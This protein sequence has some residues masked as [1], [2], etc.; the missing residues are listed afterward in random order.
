[1]ETITRQEAKAQGLMFYF[2]GKP[3][4][5]GVVTKRYV[6]NGHCSCRACMPV[7]KYTYQKKVV[8]NTCEHCGKSFTR[9]RKAKFCSA[10]CRVNVWKAEKLATD[11]AFRV[12]QRQLKRLRQ[13][14]KTQ[15]VPRNRKTNKGFGCSALGLKA[16]LEA[17]FLP[18]M[19]WD[20]YGYSGWHVD[21][22]RPIASFD[23]N[24][25]EQ[26]AECF[27]Y[28]NLQ[29]LWAVDNMAKSDKWAAA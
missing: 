8:H 11:P 26:F 5:N 28:T 6:S 29:P 4:P 10:V 16:H 15:G 14:L 12:M 23:L 13:A 22:I 17:L 21:H 1:M 3:C 24:D 19:S 20:N 25:P 27:H 9:S 2:T 18:G 7:P